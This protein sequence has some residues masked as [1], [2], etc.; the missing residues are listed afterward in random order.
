MIAQIFTT[1]ITKLL[2]G[3][4]CI[5]RSSRVSRAAQISIAFEECLQNKKAK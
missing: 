1:P 5:G 3:S 2:L 4:D